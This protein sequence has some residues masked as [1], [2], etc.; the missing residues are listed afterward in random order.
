MA[1]SAEDGHCF[2]PQ[3]ELIASAKELL[4]NQDHQAESETVEG[5]IE[6][7]VS[8][9]DLIVEEVEGGMRLYFKPTFYHT[10]NNLARI[11]RERTST[12][13]EID[14]QRVNN[15]IERYTL[16]KQIQL[17]PQREKSSRD[18]RFPNRH[19]SHRRTRLR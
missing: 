17:S 5:V 8:N 7:M 4:S 15:W 2:L 6:E 10:E 13:I 14:T 16:K 9:S 12:K 11:L 18:G 3:P 1:R 19:D